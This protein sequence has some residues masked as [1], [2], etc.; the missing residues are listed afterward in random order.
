MTTKHT[1]VHGMQ[2]SRNKKWR[3]PRAYSTPVRTL[4]YYHI[5]PIS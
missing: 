3:G 2:R 4:Y 1:N 5:L